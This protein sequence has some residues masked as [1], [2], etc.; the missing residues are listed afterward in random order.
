MTTTPQEFFGRRACFVGIESEHWTREQII[1]AAARI[2]TFGYDTLVLKVADGGIRWYD[3]VQQL[4]QLHHD[5]N[6][7]G[8]GLALYQYCYGP[9]FGP[10]Q[11]TAEAAIANEIATI[12]NF[13]ILDMETEYDNQPTAAAEFARQLDG[14]FVVST[15][16]DPTQQGWDGVAAALWDSGKIAEFWPQEYSRWLE[17][18]G[19]RE[20]L[21]D[22]V[23]VP[24]YHIANDPLP[25]YCIYDRY[26]VWEYSYPVPL[27]RAW[28]RVPVR[29]DVA[30]PVTALTT[31]ADRASAL[32]IS[33]AAYRV[34]HADTLS[35]LAAQRSVAT[36]AD[37]T[38]IPTELLP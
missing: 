31:I 7:V 8:T 10:Q 9:L 29:G 12:S 4:S 25:D 37:T 36:I 28:G 34:Q 30:H 5:V 2:R 1:S 21:R 22:M 6:A 13:P 24:T 17:Y 3:D 27:L 35:R 15:W 38:P 26:S 18:T 32:G 16:A 20:Y 11:I 14:H 19:G 33:T 23:I